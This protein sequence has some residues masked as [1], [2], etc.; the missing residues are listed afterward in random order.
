[1]FLKKSKNN[2]LKSSHYVTLQDLMI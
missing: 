2:I 1:M